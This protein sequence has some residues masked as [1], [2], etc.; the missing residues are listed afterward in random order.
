MA[1]P[2]MLQYLQ[3][4]LLGEKES[5]MCKETTLIERY[6][7]AFNRH[8]L[9]DVMACFADDALITG[10]HGKRIEGAAAMRA[11]YAAAFVTFPDAKCTIRTLVGDNGAGAVESLFTGIRADKDQPISMMGVEVLEFRGNKISELR[12]YHRPT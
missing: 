9:E 2:D 11:Y 10:A 4:N 1:T 7:D 6:F 3:E 5:V 12:D 8:D